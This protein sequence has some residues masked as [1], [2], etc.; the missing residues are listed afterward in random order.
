MNIKKTNTQ[1]MNNK[2]ENMINKDNSSN[3]SNYIFIG[4]ILFFTFIVFS[5][6]IDNSFTNW[7]D[8][9][10][11]INNKYLKDISASGIKTIFTTPYFANYHPLTTLSYALEYNF[12]S[13]TI[14][15]SKVADPISFHFINLLLH[16]LN[17]VLVYI[18]IIM[19]SKRKEIAIIVSLLF[20]IHPM[21][22]ESVSWISERKDVLY[23]FFFL[24]SMIFYLKYIDSEKEGKK[25]YSFSLIAFVLSL[26]SKSAAVVLPLILIIIDYYKSKDLKNIK[27][28]VDK[29]PFFILSIIMGIVTIWSQTKGGGINVTASFSFVDKIFLASYGIA[30][31]IIKLF[32]P[33]NLSAIH[34]FPEKASNLLPLIYYISPIIILLIV[35]L[36]VKL[37]NLKKD[38]VFGVL[39]FLSSMVLV[40]QF[41][42]IGNAV[43]AER[44]TY[45]PYIGLFFIVGKVYCSIIDN[46][47]RYSSALK[48]YINY[49][50]IFFV[51]F[52]A[53]ISYNRNKVW[54][55]GET[56]FT[57]VIEKY[58]DNYKSYYNRGNAR[59]QIAEANKG[60]GMENVT[61]I[62]VG[63][64]KDY[65][66]AIE[67][68]S[69]DFDS[70]NNRGN[71]RL[72]LKDYNAA[73]V[74]L[75]EAIKINPKFAPAYY[76]KGLALVNTQEYDEAIKC[77]D[78][79]IELNTEY[80]DA[81]LNR[82]NI[83]SMNKDYVNA[84]SDYN[85]ALK[86][87][88]ELT[89]G[90]YNRGLVKFYLKDTTGACMDWNVA[91]GRGF[92][93][94]EQWIGYY[95]K[96]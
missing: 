86:F 31:Y 63:A 30:F 9:D 14:N 19:L 62:Y 18:F 41:I 69:K 65:D 4:I 8:P 42:T 64:I 61:E 90:Y 15:G 57:D 84:L 89:G 34:Y 92:K 48:S 45:I 66:K 70:Y 95:C 20:A 37:K 54:Q 77:F 94:A 2:R 71:T 35:L 21:H 58:P 53:I 5:N 59:R 80:A 12:F 29:I 85:N 17:V 87:N 3:K 81:F 88:S 6:S 36:I 52:F 67:L 32:L 44:Y 49:I 25:Y 16:L 51:I 56:L 96:K 27:N 47:N 74:D 7:D 39:F 68:N 46:K 72:D 78:R 79:A 60:A 28:I 33:L 75:R 40:L 82:G 83:K 11:I 93:D 55:D 23:S 10:Y 1:A 13:K 22:V 26:L 91:N 50:L 24:I 43:V 38:F 76:N 73:I